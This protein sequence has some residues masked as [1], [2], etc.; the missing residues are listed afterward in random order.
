M[1]SRYF[2]CVARNCLVVLSAIMLVAGCRSVG[3]PM[4]LSKSS[5]ALDLSRKSIVIFTVR[6]TNIYKPDH[7][8]NLERVAILPANCRKPVT[9]QVD[10]PSSRSAKFCDYMVSVEIEPGVHALKTVAGTALGMS[11]LLSQNSFEFQVD[12]RFEALTNA[13]TYIGHV[14]MKNRERKRGEPRSGP[15]NPI[16][17]QSVAGFLGG[18]FDVS[19]SDLQETDIPLFVRT[20]P[21]L[22]EAMI[23]T[24]IMSL[25]VK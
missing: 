2:S 24:A 23:G 15:I 22:R 8:P 18:T 5:G 1:R 13:V 9:F 16:L 21:C 19:V 4:A 14:D 7:Q 6:T 25:P 10:K 17:P 3:Q 11:L 12:G 20:Y